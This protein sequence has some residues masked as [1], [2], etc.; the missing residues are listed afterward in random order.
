MG[1]LLAEIAMT[2]MG[3]VTL[4]RGRI[5]II[6]DKEVRGIPAYLVGVLLVGTFPLVIVAAIA[7]GVIAALSGQPENAAQAGAAG[8]FGSVLFILVASAIIA[9]VWGGHPSAAP[10]TPPANWGPPPGGYSPPGGY[11]T[12]PMDPNNPYAPPPGNWP[13]DPHQR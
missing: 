4:V 6:R 13:Q 9:A 8:E 5:T 10:P 1:C 7:G 3:I 11:P 12:P 2:I